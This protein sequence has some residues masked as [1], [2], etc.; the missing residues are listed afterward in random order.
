MNIKYFY[1]KFRS[2]ILRVKEGENLN[3]S[4]DYVANPSTL[5]SIT[6]LRDHKSFSMNASKHILQV[7]ILF[8]YSVECRYL[9]D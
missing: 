2:K 4:C 1:L 8:L 6:W 5:T 7:D 3:I 9:T